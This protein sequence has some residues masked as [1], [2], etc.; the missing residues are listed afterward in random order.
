MEENKKT[1]YLLQGGIIFLLVVVIVLVILLIKAKKNINDFEMSSLEKET[2]KI[3]NYY[4]MYDNEYD[5]VEKGIY[6]ALEYSLNEFGKSELSSNE[7]KKIIDQKFNND[8]TI[9]EITSNGVTPLLFDSGINYDTMNNKYTL[10]KRELNQKEIAEKEIVI[11]LP[12]KT[13]KKKDNYVINYDKYVISNPYEI[14]NYFNNKENSN[15]ESE[16]ILNYLTGK[17]SN[18][19]EVKK[20]INKE[21]INNFGKK[22]K[23]IKITFTVKNNSLIINEVK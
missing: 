4:E 20:L 6:Y 16:I 14:L 5:K 9:E 17:N 19:N 15:E 22:E 2:T 3:M 21:N 10:N 7:I 11:Y 13:K 23:N 12:E 1:K 18:I 8:I